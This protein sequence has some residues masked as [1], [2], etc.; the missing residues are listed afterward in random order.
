LPPSLAEFLKRRGFDAIH[1]MDCPQGSL[2]SD[3]EIINIASK[4]SRIVITK[5]SDFRDYYFLR[6]YPP[7]VFLLQ[8]GNI[9]NQ[10]LFFL[11]DE[12]IE[13]I[14]SLFSNQTKFLILQK[15]R[16]IFF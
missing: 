7:A 15:N 8:L 6:G 4:E 3:K 12:H 1:V 13:Q 9:K 11:L 10:E 2:T 16:I 5:D 14:T